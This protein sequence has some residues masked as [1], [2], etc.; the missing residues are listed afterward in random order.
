MRRRGARSTPRALLSRSLAG[1]RG[2]T[3]IVNLPGSS[4]GAVESLEAIAP[5]LGHAV[6]L[7]MGHTEH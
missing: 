6:E 7:L 4:T 3:L 5:V 1:V 2:Q